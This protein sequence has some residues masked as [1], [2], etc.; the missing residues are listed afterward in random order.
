MVRVSQNFLVSLFYTDMQFTYSLVYFSS[1]FSWL[2]YFMSLFSDRN[3]SLI[4][5]WSWFYYFLPIE[6]YARRYVWRAI[7]FLVLLLLYF[8]GLKRHLLNNPNVFYFVKVLYISY[9]TIVKDFFARINCYHMVK[10]IFTDLWKTK[11]YSCYIRGLYRKET[12][13]TDLRLLN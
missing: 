9:F 4:R 13:D 7:F 2:F 5:V 10:Q 6:L 3:N 12:H 1:S 8:I 11:C